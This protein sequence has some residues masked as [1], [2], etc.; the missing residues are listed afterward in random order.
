MQMDKNAFLSD[1]HSKITNIREGPLNLSRS[2]SKT[3]G[4]PFGCS[5]MCVEADRVHSH[6]IH[7][8]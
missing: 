4:A 6:N 3:M 1:R 8:W 2:Y 7:H 5:S